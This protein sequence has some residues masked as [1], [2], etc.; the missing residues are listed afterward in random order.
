MLG[1]FGHGFGGYGY[2][3]GWGVGGQYPET[4][5]EEVQAHRLPKVHTYTTTILNLHNP[6]T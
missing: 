4:Q 5:M 3:L 2:E 6:S 1:V